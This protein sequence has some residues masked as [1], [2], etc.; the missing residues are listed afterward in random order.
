MGGPGQ[1]AS[2]APA[3]QITALDVRGAPPAGG[4]AVV[5]TGK[6]FEAGLDVTFGGVA[7]TAV[8]VDP[9][10][11]VVRCVTP[12]HA[13]GACD[14]VVSNPDGQ[15]A[16]ISGFAYEPPPAPQ[17]FFPGSAAVG[18]TFTV[19]GVGLVPGMSGGAEV[20]VGGVKAT[21]VSSV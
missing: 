20:T 15:S 5:I 3:P 11:E 10:G 18:A 6:G 8:S 16:T 17:S 4:T 2:P 7:A 13:A 14:V 1:A 19:L 21:I 9:A 12:A